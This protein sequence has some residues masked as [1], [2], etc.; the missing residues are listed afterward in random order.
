MPVKAVARL[1]RGWVGTDVLPE[2]LGGTAALD[3]RL[4][5]PFQD[6]TVTG[7]AAV[8]PVVV[9]PGAGRWPRDLA[10]GRPGRGAV[11]G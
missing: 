4:R 3:L 9:R 5:G 10:A 1:L 8:A 7:D 2:R 6:L 11:R